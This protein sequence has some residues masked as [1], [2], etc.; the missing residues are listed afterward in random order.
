MNRSGL[1]PKLFTAMVCLA[2]AQ[3][4][5]PQA[6]AADDLFQDVIAAWNS[7]D[8]G[9]VASLFTDDAVYEDVTLG[10]TSHGTAE[11]QKFAKQAFVDIPDFRMELTGSFS[12]DGHGYAEW[13]LTGIDGN[14]FK[15]HKP[16]SVRGVSIADMA[17][18]KF[19]HNSDY[20]D[21]AT[22][23]KQVGVSP[24]PGQGAQ[25]AH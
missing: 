19:S 6:V 4:R 13:T 24:Q 12:K 3:L 20:W 25:P 9:K 18:G 22:V 10:A 11:I 23:M 7:H 21:L 16:F 8:A 1:M 2:L 14:V 17:N 5:S 15:T